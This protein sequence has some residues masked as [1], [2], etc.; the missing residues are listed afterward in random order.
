MRGGSKLAAGLVVLVTA[1]VAPALALQPPS[2]H[3]KA[4]FG[5]GSPSRA[6]VPAAAAPGFAKSRSR[7][8]AAKHST[9]KQAASRAQKS[10]SAN[11][12]PAPK[13]EA[14]APAKPAAARIP[15]PALQFRAAAA[16]LVTGWPFTRPGSPGWFGV[17]PSAHQDGGF[18]GW[19]GPLFWPYAYDDMFAYVFWPADSFEHGEAFWA[20]AYEDLFEGIFWAD[21]AAGTGQAEI[22]AAA[23]GDG[24]D[25]MERSGAGEGPSREFALICGERTPGLSQWPILRIAQSVGLTLEQ[26]LALKQLQAAAGEAARLLK[27]ACPTGAP[28]TPLERIDAMLERV[29]AMLRAVDL[30]SPALQRF[31]EPLS[32]AQKAPFQAAPAMGAGDEAA[33]SPNREKKLFPRICGD[34]PG[35]LVVR[36]LDRLETVVRPTEAQHAALEELRTAAAR[37]AQILRD[38]CPAGTPSNPVERLA[39][40]RQRL[41][42]MRAAATLVRPAL[43]GFYGSLTDAQKARFNTVGKQAG[44]IA[45]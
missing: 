32:E 20:F 16:G 22:V 36:T 42:A 33:A 18:V 7:G 23:E 5:H 12:S 38:A 31:Y 11:K 30:V 39:A 1:A 45:D 4:S 13:R 9:R 41:E 27:S 43:Q 35:A 15:R 21:A 3:A 8:T 25:S 29:E 2:T 14:R 17:A 37:A 19:F 44:R 24:S 6:A 26:R 10:S 40:M 34:R 28:K